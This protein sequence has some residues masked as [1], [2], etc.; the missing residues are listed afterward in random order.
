MPKPVT[1]IERQQDTGDVP[2]EDRTARFARLKAAAIA[3][4]EAN[5]LSEAE[6]LALVE[7][8]RQRLFDE[9]PQDP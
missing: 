1:C 4:A 5:E 7:A 3:N 8:E 2:D 9:Q 6:A